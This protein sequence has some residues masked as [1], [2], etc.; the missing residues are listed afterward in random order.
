[1]GDPAVAAQ[2]QERGAYQLA[3]VERVVIRSKA[4]ASGIHAGFHFE[5]Q[6]L[7]MALAQEDWFGS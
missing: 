3:R 6:D 5:G 4:L 2:I 7:I 1:M